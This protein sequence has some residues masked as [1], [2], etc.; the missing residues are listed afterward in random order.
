MKCIDCSK[1]Q[2]VIDDVTNA[3]ARCILKTPPKKGKIITWACTSYKTFSDLLL[4]KNKQLGINRVKEILTR[5]KKA[6]VWCPLKDKET[7]E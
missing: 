5:K 1:C 7:I 4:D 3:K 6:P 2:I